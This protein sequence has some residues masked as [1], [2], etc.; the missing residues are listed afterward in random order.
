[1]TSTP[2]SAS[3]PSTPSGPPPP[4][5]TR[6]WMFAAAGSVLAAALAV[7]LF[8]GVAPGQS[9]PSV[10]EVTA[11]GL[12]QAASQMLA[13][14]MFSASSPQY[15]PNFTLTDQRGRAVSLS[16]F[17]G[18]VVVMSANDDQC[19]DLCTFL[20]SDIVV[21]NHDLGAAAKRVV[22]LSVNANPYYP[23][24][25]AVAAWTDQH[26][27][28]NQPNWYFTT[29]S[30]AALAKVWQLYGVTVEAD[31]RTRSITHSTG[32]TYIDPGGRERAMAEFGTAAANTALFGHSLAQLADDLLPPGQRVKVAGPPVP[33]PSA[34][35]AAVGAAASPFHLPF[36]GRPGALVSSSLRGRFSVVNFWASTCTVCRTELPGVEKAYRFAGSK[37]DF[38]GIDVSDGAAPARA[39]AGAAGLTYPLVTD[40]SG[41]IAGAD[42][43][44]GLPFTLILDPTGHVLVRHPGDI[45]AE[46]LEYLLESYVPALT[47][48]GS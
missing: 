29:G 27:L 44:T 2:A 43:V 47:P 8:V 9:Q 41:A 7:I 24:V 5:R 30:P 36:L 3:A 28:G 19:Q 37:V 4:R 12:N 21:A 38:V 46:Q 20:A 16:Q 34:G 26:G 11:P 32:M 22:W 1:V 45:T 6:P 18:K 33:E 23:G 15:A 39:M 42:R 31:P 48:A 17:R 14:D 13:L 25:S 40:R 10:P 35:G